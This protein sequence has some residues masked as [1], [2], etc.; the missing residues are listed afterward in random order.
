LRIEC[1]EHAGVYR[2]AVQEDR[3]RSTLPQIAGLLGASKPEVLAEREEQGA[4]VRHADGAS[5]PIDLQLDV[6]E[7]LLAAMSRSGSGPIGLAA[8]QLHLPGRSGKGG[9]S[10]HEAG[11]RLDKRTPGWIARFGCAF[12]ARRQTG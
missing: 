3:A 8:Q 11:A 12:Q 6:R 4:L 5:Q 7:R 9:R 1:E 2:L 10:D